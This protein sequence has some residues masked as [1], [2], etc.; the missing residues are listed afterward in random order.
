MRNLYVGI[1]IGP[2][3]G[4][5]TAERFAREGYDV[6]IT[7]RDKPKLNRI[8]E[9]LSANTGRK[10]EAVTL[11][12]NDLQ[13]IQGL[14][15]T[16]GESTAVLHYNAAAMHGTSIYDSSIASLDQDI[17]VDIT[18][19]LVAIKAFTVFMKASKQ[20][21]VLLTGGGFALSPSAEYLTLS[22]GKAGIRAMAEG[23]F[24]ELAKS[25]IHIATVTVAK[26][27][28]AGS[29]AAEAAAEAF[30]NLHNQPMEAWSWE[31]I[32]N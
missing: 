17:R 15:D 13:A 29:Q 18:G 7:G 21:T 8:A 31:F 12:A 5:S 24:P 27:V 23:L 1:G 16:Y 14:A 25:G 28:S 9:R 22:I 2:G 4:L 10:V 20:G 26:N 3:M 6:I 32:L 30:W 19:A 11:D